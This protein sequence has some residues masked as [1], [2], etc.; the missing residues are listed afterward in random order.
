[1][2]ISEA[3]K[4][5]LMRLKTELKGKHDRNQRMIAEKRAELEAL[6]AQ[7]IAIR[8]ELDA[9]IADIAELVSLGPPVVVVKAKGKTAK[10]T[11]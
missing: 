8:A 11:K 1:M 2:A 5:A 3:T 9:L 10:K 4:Q 7:G 6:E